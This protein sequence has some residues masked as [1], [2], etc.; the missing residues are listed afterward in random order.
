[1][2]RLWTRPAGPRHLGSE[3]YGWGREGQELEGL[4]QLDFVLEAAGSP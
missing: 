4:Q 1:M 3:K 2:Q